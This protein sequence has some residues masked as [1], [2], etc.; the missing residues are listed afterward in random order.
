MEDL[1]EYE[2]QRAARLA[3][4]QAM[5]ASLGL[6]QVAQEFEQVVSKEEDLAEERVKE[7][8]QRLRVASLAIVGGVRRSS[9]LRKS[10]ASDAGQ[11]DDASIQRVEILEGQELE[12]V[13]CVQGR[14]EGLREFEGLGRDSEGPSGGD[15]D[16]GASEDDYRPDLDEL[17]QGELESEPE[18]ADVSEG[19]LDCAGSGGMMDGTGQKR[20]RKSSASKCAS[21]VSRKR[22]QAINMAGPVL[23]EDETNLQMALAL[24]R[25]DLGT[26]PANNITQ[27]EPSTSAPGMTEDKE[28][29]KGKGRKAPQPQTDFF[30]STEEQHREI[31]ALHAAETGALRSVPRE[32]YSGFGGRAGAGQLGMGA[33]VET[34][35]AG[36]YKENGASSGGLSQ[37][38]PRVEAGAGLGG[39]KQGGAGLAGG[40]RDGSGGAT[41]A[42]QSEGKGGKGRKQKGKKVA[43]QPP[44]LDEIDALFHLFDDR[45]RGQLSVADVRH[46]AEAHDFTWSDEQL[47]DM[48]GMFDADND[49]LMGQ[50]DFRY[51]VQ[52]CRVAL[53]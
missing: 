53:N 21:K 37:D 33:K 16:G 15:S 39:D 34:S 2:K 4:N 9:R 30:W 28:T 42:V 43:A 40:L 49:G 52:H 7:A 27:N 10:G 17:S 46:V 13:G 24:S 38:D 44:T 32:S 25:Q 22:K 41:E 8:E 51:L 12:G 31:Q 3:E 45:G 1:T 35:A 48:V 19:E 11:D 18:A 20:R 26:S 36:G 47:Q 14:Q 23:D 5:L 6:E 29:A 50:D